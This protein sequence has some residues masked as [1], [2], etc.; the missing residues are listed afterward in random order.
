MNLKKCGNG[1]FYDADEC[2]SC[3]KCKGQ[4][5]APVKKEPVTG[6]LVCTEGGQYGQIFELKKGRNQVGGSADM[7]IA[8][9]GDAQVAACCQVLV[10][11]DEEKKAFT[12]NAG[13]AR[14]LSYINGQVLLFDQELHSRDVIQVGGSKLMFIPL[15]GPDFSWAE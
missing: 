12:A 1:H 6:W 10:T 2:P 7:D 4:E 8:L 9:T 13:E 15:C 14:E 5:E 11:Y 3:P